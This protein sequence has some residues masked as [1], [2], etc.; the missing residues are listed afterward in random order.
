M[1]LDELPALLESTDDLFTCGQIIDLIPA[2]WMRFDRK[3]LAV[4]AK[5][6]D[7]VVGTEL[8]GSK[9][10][11]GIFQAEP[12]QLCQGVGPFHLSDG[13]GRRRDE[14]DRLIPKHTAE[15]QTNHGLP[16]FIAVIDSCNTVASE[17]HTK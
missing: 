3:N 17:T 15:A 11:V 10:G 2:S 8:E 14:L 5:T 9:Q 13:G 6:A 16:Q 12:A 1:F 4:D 7:A